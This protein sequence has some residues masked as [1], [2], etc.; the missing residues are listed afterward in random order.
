MIPPDD[1]DRSVALGNSPWT[2]VLFWS[3]APFPPHLQLST[4]AA[5]LCVR[6][7]RTEAVWVGDTA[8]YAPARFSEAIAHLNEDRPLAISEL[9]EIQ[10]GPAQLNLRDVRG[11]ETRKTRLKSLLQVETICCWLGQQGQASQCLRHD[12][13]EFFPSLVLKKPLKPRWCIH[14]PRCRRSRSPILEVTPQRARPRQL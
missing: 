2:A 8:V 5:P 1:V 7:H 13:P 9:V 3:R 4:P 12:R 11:Q 10:N 14:A 6:K